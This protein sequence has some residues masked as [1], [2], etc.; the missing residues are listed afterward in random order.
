[1][2]IRRFS[3]PY[4]IIRIYPS[5]HVD[6]DQAVKTGDCFQ[7]EPQVLWVAHC[8]RKQKCGV[9][10]KLFKLIRMLEIGWD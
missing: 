5:F 10:V 6:I 1:M 3:K 2:P 8:F 9:V 4:Q 7:A